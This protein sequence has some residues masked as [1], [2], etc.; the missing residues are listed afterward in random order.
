MSTEPAFKALDYDLKLYGFW[1]TD[2]FGLFVLFGLVH[3]VLNSL[4]LDAVVIGPLLYLAWRGRKRPRAYLRSLL[5]Y[6]STPARLP[7]G[8]RREPR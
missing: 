3:G 1:P 6:A 5:F 7:V 4:F 8:L 2:L